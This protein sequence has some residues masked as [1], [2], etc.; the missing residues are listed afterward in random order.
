MRTA[1]LL[2][3]L[4]LPLSGCVAHRLSVAPSDC[5][6]PQSCT[7][8]LYEHAREINS[9]KLTED[10][11]QVVIDRLRSFGT[12]GVDELSNLLGWWQPSNVQEIAAC[13]LARMGP[14][15]S[16]AVPALTKYLEETS[17]GPCLDAVE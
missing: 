17:D 14:D 11:Q 10:E 7:R 2:F 1:I 4:A 9:A 6:T 16:P 3:A 13:A 8:L 5:A 12:P 15:A